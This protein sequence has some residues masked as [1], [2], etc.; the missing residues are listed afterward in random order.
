MTPTLDH[1]QFLK[2]IALAESPSDPE[3][4]AAIRKATSLA[5]AA[6]AAGLS[7]GEAVSGNFGAEGWGSG[8]SS[9]Y[10]NGRQSGFAAG[11]ESRH[12]NA[13]PTTEYQGDGFQFE[14]GIMAATE[15]GSQSTP[16]AWHAGHRTWTI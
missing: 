1:A 7:L 16:S 14:E 4:L 3:A 15:V 13:E 9:G 6:R 10:D 5:R 8:Y 11:Q 12:P 2:I